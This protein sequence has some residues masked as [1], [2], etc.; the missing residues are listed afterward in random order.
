MAGEPAAS[1]PGA[2]GKEAVPRF[3]ALTIEAVEARLATGPHGLSEAEAAR[4][5][6][7]D[8]LNRLP[9]RKPP[10]GLRR[11]LRQFRSLL[12]I[13]LLFAAAVTALLGHFVDAAVILGVVLANAAIGFVQ[14]GRAER[15]IEG[16]RA[17]LAPQASV[18]REGRRRTVEAEQLAVGDLVLIEAGDRVP[19]DLRVARSRNLQIA[20]AA[21]TGESV[22]VDKSPDAVRAD[23]PLAERSAVAFSG[24]LVTSGQGQGIVVATGARTE[25]GRIGALVAEVRPGQTPLLRQMDQFSRRLTVVILALAALIF[26]FAIVFEGYPIEE[27]FLAVVGISVAAIPE[28]LPAVLTITLAIGVRRMAHKNAIIR[29]LPAVETLGAVSVICTDK[30]GTLTRNEMTVRSVAAGDGGWRVT[31][32]GYEPSG[33]IL[34]ETGA[35]PPDRI[36]D[37]ALAASLCN[38]ATLHRSEEG[39]NVHGDPMEGALL[40]FASKAGLE[41]ARLRE[42]YPRRDAIPFAAEARFMATLHASDG[43]AAAFLKGAP[44]RLLELCTSQGGADA[45]E[46][47][48][49]TYWLEKTQRMAQSGERVLAF[50]VKRL[51]AELH[52]LEDPEMLEGAV[53]LGLVG[54]IDPPREEAVAAVRSCREA[55][56]R[57]KMITGDHPATAAAIALEV[58]IGA[59]AGVATGAD[60]DRADDAALEALAWSSDVFARTSPEHKL[61]LVRALQS[62]GAI[63]AMTGDGVNDSPALK[64]AD[65]GVAMGRKGTEAA[66]EAAAMVLADDNFASIVAA[67][68]EGRTVY[69]NLKK[70]IAFALPTNGGESL[71]IVAAILLGLTLPITPVQI[72]WI[73]M[74]TAVALDLTLTFEPTE[75]GTMRRPPRARSEPLLSGFLVWRIAFVSLLFLAGAFAMFYWASSNGRP[76]E[77]ARTLVVN[78]IVAMEIFYLFNVRFQHGPSITWRGVLGTRAVVVGVGL[79]TVLQL[80]FTYAPPFQLMFETRPVGLADGA[81]TVAAG[82]ALLIVLEAEKALLLRLRRSIRPLLN[83]PSG[84]ERRPDASPGT[85]S[86]APL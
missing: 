34:S 4:R 31:G 47:L 32:V 52:R 35:G 60:L 16:I 50:A 70:V 59:G 28:G 46:P 57:V 75:P 2:G 65:V 53:L 13:V 19:A 20:E 63:V 22:P 61:R 6:A 40:A 14:E 21:L 79:V 38:D 72:L 23:A 42:L 74:V 48:D 82:L 49:R 54:L 81:L 27:A 33:E 86:R 67:V 66:K 18:I 69:D 78:T 1:G 58:G 73:N 5:I 68:R 26:A 36:A 71:T 77:E 8:G 3:H 64:Q 85:A 84:P 62:G 37:L 56:I 39:W 9:G 11:F 29:N 30:T 76:V 43:A 7:A 44:E 17:M 51:P 83:G 80:A 45:E 41:P 24:T 12:I 25:I 15:A 10:S 55:G